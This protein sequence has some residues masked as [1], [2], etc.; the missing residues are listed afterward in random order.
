M[1]LVDR[2][3]GAAVLLAVVAATM[4]SSAGVALAQTTDADAQT[5]CRTAVTTLVI[6]RITAPTADQQQAI[7]TANT[8]CGA[9]TAEDADSSAILAT[10][11]AALPAA[12]TGT[13]GTDGTD[14]ETT[15]RSEVVAACRDAVVGVSGATSSAVT[16]A[17]ALCDGLSA[18]D[19]FA[20]IL[21]GVQASVPSTTTSGSTS[22]G[23][24]LDCSD[25]ADRADAQTALAADPTDP[26]GL[27]ADHDGTACE[28]IPSAA[29]STASGYPSG[30]VASGD[31]STEGPD[32]GEIALL[33]MVGVTALS[34]AARVA[35][36]R[37][38][39]VA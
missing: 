27:D 22:S 18:G 4:A 28:A 21:A 24:G 13:N 30:G 33:V 26:D 31:G 8:S 7:D 11:R 9:L 12:P 14:G 23:T 2:A 32:L 20:A 35:L 3:R 38:A 39:K 5:A 29:V 6:S 16:Q 15:G 19:S 36:A 10:L 37:A 25:F 17:Y 34:G 1:R